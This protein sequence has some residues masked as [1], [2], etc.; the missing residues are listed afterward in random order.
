[1]RTWAFEQQGPCMADLC[2]NVLEEI[3]PL[4][5]PVIQSLIESHFFYHNKKY[6]TDIFP[7]LERIDRQVNLVKVDWLNVAVSGSETFPVL[8]FTEKRI[9]YVASQMRLPWSPRG[10]KWIWGW[11]RKQV[12]SNAFV[13][14]LMHFQ[15]IHN[16]IQQSEMPRSK[17]SK[18]WEPS[19]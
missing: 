11:S 14:C 6:V 5:S 17:P 9:H 16:L 8:R 1:M 4:P 2:S 13:A 12:E 3:E 7:I 18:K 19:F 10:R 15:V